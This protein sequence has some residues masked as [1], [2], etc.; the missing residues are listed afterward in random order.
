MVKKGEHL[1]TYSVKDKRDAVAAIK[2]GQMTIK[3]VA[4]TLKAPMGTVRY[5]VKRAEQKTLPSSYT[6][7]VCGEI[8]GDYHQ[9]NGH[10]VVHRKSKHPPVTIQEKPPLVII[11]EK[12]SVSAQAPR[13]TLEEFVNLLHDLVTDYEISKTRLHSLEKSVEGWKKQAGALNEQ[14]RQMGGIS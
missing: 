13:I 14:M 8:F 7:K 6:C 10:L 3:E 12:P 9:L 2:S 11:G 1:K 4:A 5:W